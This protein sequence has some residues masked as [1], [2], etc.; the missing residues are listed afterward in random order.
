MTARIVVAD[1]EADIRRLI[2]FALRRRGHTVMETGTG[3]GALALI[4]AERPQLAILDVMMPGM[5]GLA[6][7]EALGADPG[8]AGLPILM[9][10]AKGQAAEIEEGLRS[11][12]CAYLVKPFAPAALI[13]QVTALLGAGDGAGNR[14]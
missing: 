7:A 13:A 6:V 4:R 10:S 8:T 9:L 3:D 12:A 2:V 11:G 14:G 1:D 5:S